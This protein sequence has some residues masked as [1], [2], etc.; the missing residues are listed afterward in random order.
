MF[1]GAH[2]GMSCLG[3]TYLG[4][5]HVIELNS[6]EEEEQKQENIYNMSQLINNCIS[7][8]TLHDYGFFK[9]KSFFY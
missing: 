2:K 1:P 4:H 5:V 9:L 3:F 7:N 6:F 8:F